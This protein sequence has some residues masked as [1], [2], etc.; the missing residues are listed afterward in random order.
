M[1]VNVSTGKATLTDI[2]C[3]NVVSEGKTGDISLRNVIA[4]KTISVARSTGDVRFDHSDGGAIFVKTDT[5]DVTGSLLTDKVFLAQS[6]TGD[7][8]VPKTTVGGKC[9]IKTG[10][11]DIIITIG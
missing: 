11:G 6:S 2:R 1:K 5:G 3:K 7:V 4:V 9:E 8:D 10:T